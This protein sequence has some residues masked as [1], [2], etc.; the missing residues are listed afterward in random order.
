M[1]LMDKMW[2]EVK[3]HHLDHKGMNIWVYE[4]NNS[5]FAG[6]ELAAP[7]RLHTELELKKIHLPR[8]AYYK[9]IGSYGKIREIGSKVL[10]ELNQKGIKTRLPYLEIYGHWTEDESQLETELLWCLV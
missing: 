9:H 8:Y 6:V 1:G 7:P 10:N 4:D 3:S 2:K 5:V